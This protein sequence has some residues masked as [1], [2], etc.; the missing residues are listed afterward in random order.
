MKCPHC[1]VCLSVVEM[2]GPRT[3]SSDSLVV[4]AGCAEVSV[5]DSRALRPMTFSETT[6]CQK[7]P[8]WNSC[9]VPAQI[10]ARRLR[11]ARSARNN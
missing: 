6:A 1:N 7:H 9:I 5:Y 3:G 11:M 2:N 4:C 8:S 10:A